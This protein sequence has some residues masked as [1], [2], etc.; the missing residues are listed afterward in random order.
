MSIASGPEQATEPCRVIP[1]SKSFARFMIG[2]A[3]AYFA[4]G[5]GIAFSL[6]RGDGI[7]GAKAL[8]LAAFGIFGTPFILHRGLK[9]ASG[10][11]RLV[12]GRDY[13]EERDG[14]AVVA[15]IPFRNLRAVNWTVAGRDPVIAFVLVAPDDPATVYKR[16]SFRNC[17]RLYGYDYANAAAGYELPAAQILVLIRQSFT[18]FSAE[19]RR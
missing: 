6:W 17:R 8:V 4:I 10:K 3:V 7:F 18:A 11:V 16:G 12:V 15:H 9:L 19:A 14:D 5:W 13:F 2:F 1:A